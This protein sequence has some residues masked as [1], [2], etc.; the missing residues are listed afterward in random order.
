VSENGAYEGE[1]SDV[2]L[3]MNALRAAVPAHPDPRLGGD[4]VPRLAAAA[5][6][7]TIEAE[8]PVMRRG[9]A[10]GTGTARR[11]RR[12]LHTSVARVAV[13]IALIPL[14]LAGL[15]VAGV[16]VPSPARSAFDAI[17]ITLPNQPPQESE[18][19]AAEQSS[20]PATRST[21]EPGK[22]DTQSKGNSHAAQQHALAQQAKAEAKASDRAI[23]HTRG[24]AIGLNELTPPGLSG[25]T[26]PPA[27][28]NAGGSSNGHANS[29]AHPPHPTPVPSGDATGQTTTLQDQTV[30]GQ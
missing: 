29:H 25:E 26:G 4:L 20:Q 22:S 2:V 8:T 17:G 11:R 5:R 12:S 9:A 16:T 13:A 7:S 3:F 24:K 6:A 27:H 23:G 10:D 14:V 1:M 15:A 28:P 21:S 19:G 18:E 30:V